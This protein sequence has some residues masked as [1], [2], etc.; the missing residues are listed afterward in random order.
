M[1][2]LAILIGNSSYKSQGAL[3]CCANDLEAVRGLLEATGRY[4]LIESLLD[5]DAE[6][7][8]NALRDTIDQTS[9]LGEILFYFTG[10]GHQHEAE[11]YFCA[12]NFD[13]KRPNETGLSMSEFHQLIRPANPGLLVQIIDACHSGAR[14]IK[15]DFRYPVVG[16]GEFNSV[17]QIA[18]CLDNQVSLTGD[19]LS[20]FTGSFC[21]AALSKEEGTLFY[22]DLTA[23]LRDEYIDNESQTPHFISQGAGREIFV[24]DAARLAAF[25]IAFAE[26]WTDDTDS[27]DGEDEREDSRLVPVPPLSRMEILRSAE[28]KLVRPEHLK[29]IA[30]GIFDGI[31]SRLES[32]AFSEMFDLEI[33]AHSDFQEKTTRGYIIKVLHREARADNFVTADIIR[34]RRS[35]GRFGLPIYAMAGLYGDDDFDET[36]MLDLNCKMDRAQLRISLLPKFKL[37]KKMVLVVSCA[38]SLELCYVFEMLTSHKRVDFDAFDSEG[39]ELVKRWYK[40]GWTDDVTWI[41]EDVC[42]KL[43][44]MVDAQIERAVGEG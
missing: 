12:S 7:L 14:L 24:E 29:A 38:P 5:V 11:F 21:R 26:K 22:T 17:I 35:R 43:F 30:D 25:R 44:E 8:K 27:D 41:V 18:S 13:P 1:T 19:P 42:T 34:T 28:A 36:W 20:E 37:L 16:K 10:H 9:D 32:N 3:P 31:T 15:K 33:V 23:A 6:Q 39:D 4:E 40:Q 2:N